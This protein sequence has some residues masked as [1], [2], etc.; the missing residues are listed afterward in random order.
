MVPA[1][2]L[3]SHSSWLRSES[4]GSAGSASPAQPVSTRAA[5]A[6]T[7]AMDTARRCAPLAR[8]FTGGSFRGPGPSLDGRPKLTRSRLNTQPCRFAEWTEE[9]PR[10]GLYLDALDDHRG[11]LADTDAHGREAAL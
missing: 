11:A 10:F 7:L 3:R 9:G 2:R 5:A 8:A 6:N 4:L 1:S